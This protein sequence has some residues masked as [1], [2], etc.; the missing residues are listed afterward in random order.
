L[1]FIHPW[2]VSYEEKREKPG[3]SNP[4]RLKRTICSEK[5]DV[6]MDRFLNQCL[7]KIS[8]Q[9]ITRNQRNILKHGP[10][11]RCDFSTLRMFIVIEGSET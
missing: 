11:Y 9:D 10:F 3:L 8:A 2:H 4:S 7:L 6:P 5:P 1:G